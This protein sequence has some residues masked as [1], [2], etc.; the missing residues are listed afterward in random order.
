MEFDD[1]AR[2]SLLKKSADFILRLLGL[3]T[4][5]GMIAAATAMMFA[6]KWLVVNE[7][8]LEAD[9]IVV[10][11]GH[12]ARPLY[13]AE[14]YQ[15]AYARKIYVSRPIRP[16]VSKTL[17]PLG[18][19]LPGQ[20]EVY[21]EILTR[22]GVKP[23]DIVLFGNNVL[24]TVEEAESLQH[25]FPN[26]PKRLLVVTSPMHT[27]RAKVIFSSVFPQTG[28]VMLATPYDRFPEKWWRHRQTSIELVL[29]LSKTVFYYLGGAYRSTDRT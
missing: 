2:P 26:P 22:K 1:I 14:L 20:E 21:R 13:A 9:G 8:P 16:E 6:S 11:I 5:I 12:Y 18:V 10:L 27:R 19:R 23:S 28:I 25:I 7:Q 15:Q 4:L 29:E 3:L 24:S 17:K